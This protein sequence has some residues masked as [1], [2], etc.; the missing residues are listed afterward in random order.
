MAQPNVIFD[1]SQIKY[2]IEL[3]LLAGDFDV[4]EDD[5]LLARINAGYTL[6]EFSF[7]KLIVS[8]WGDGKSVP[9]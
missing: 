6:A 4:F 9:A 5:R 1:L 8:C 7:G 3:F 2:E